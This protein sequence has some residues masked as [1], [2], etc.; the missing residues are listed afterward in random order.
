V[1]DGNDVDVEV[2]HMSD[3]DISQPLAMPHTARRDLVFSQIMQDL[4]DT[5]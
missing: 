3:E 5:P 2:D 4:N 1:P